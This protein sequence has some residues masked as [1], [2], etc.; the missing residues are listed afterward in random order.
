MHSRGS[1]KL[2]ALAFR[3]RAVRPQ[4]L[5][6]VGA[7]LTCFAVVLNVGPFAKGPERQAARAIAGQPVGLASTA[8]KRNGAGVQRDRFEPTMQAT[9]AT[10]PI[11]PLIAPSS[12]L[13]NLPAIS[14]A[15]VAWPVAQPIGPKDADA[16]IQAAP[17]RHDPGATGPAA[18]TQATIVGIW[19]PDASACSANNFREGLLPAVINTDGAWAGETFCIFKNQRQTE[20]DWRVVASCSNPREHWTARVRLTVKGNRLT[21]TSKRGTQAYTRCASDVLM[22]EAR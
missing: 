4:E 12:I 18:Q 15:A 22:A 8:R 16:E 10:D 9:Y 14:D 7:L 2:L 3:L 19:A 20:T 6:A 17:P 21:W 13:V 1:A 11:R 5:A